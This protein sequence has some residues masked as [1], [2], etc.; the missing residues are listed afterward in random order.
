M[1]KAVCFDFFNTLSY[2]HPSREQIYQKAAADLGIKV[3][4]KDI[5]KSLLK[6]D[7]FWRDE[8]RI[9]PYTQRNIIS[10]LNLFT[11]YI[12]MIINGSGGNI[13]YFD[14]FRIM[15]KLIKIKWDFALFDDAIP[16]LKSLRAKGLILGVISNVDKNFDETYRKLGIAD[17]IDFNV[18]SQE[19]GCE[20]PEA[21][22]FLTAL[23]KANL[24]AEE[25][26]FIGDQYTVDV[27]GARNVGMKAILLDRYNWQDDITD[28]PRIQGLPQVEQY[29]T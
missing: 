2:Y 21:E 25:T 8:S 27:V 9:K 13:S 15:L 24:K 18:T 4:Q 11:R 1:I 6:A 29:L 14:A 5:S 22:I 12:R 3:E 19:A 17:Y 26:I 20:K 28:C 16:T 23:R 7:L 10:R